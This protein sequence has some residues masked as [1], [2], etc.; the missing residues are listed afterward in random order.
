MLTF[1]PIDFNKYGKS[2]KLAPKAQLTDNFQIAQMAAAVI[3]ITYTVDDGQDFT[4]TY[5][6]NG[7]VAVKNLTCYL[8]SGFDDC[9]FQVIQDQLAHSYGEV[10]Q[11]PDATSRFDCGYFST[12]DDV[13]HSKYNYP[14]YCRRNT[15]VQEFAYLYKEYNPD[16]RQKI[17]PR[18]TERVIKASS[19]SCN[20]YSEI[21]SRQATVGDD[22]PN[23]I[24]A[25]NF[26]YT[27]GQRNGTI[28]IP[29]SA[30]GHEGTT[31]IYLGPRPPA[32]ATTYGSGPRGIVMWV[33]RNPGINQ[34]PR[35]F[36]CPVTVEV[37]TNVRNPAHNISDS[38]A[39]EAAASIALQGQFRNSGKE[40]DFTQWQWYASG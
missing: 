6:R 21:G 14:Y 18:F 36:E 31:Y 13:I 11:G 23:T 32:E 15:T 28:V 4:G 27:N 34:E 3:S 26:T 19:G 10:T 9:P 22:F 35:F 40:R 1:D 39:R 25:L 37:V 30:L 20:E 7:N 29:T 24:S 12:M 16:D 17:Y 38:T 8:H 5:L 2:L 33:Y